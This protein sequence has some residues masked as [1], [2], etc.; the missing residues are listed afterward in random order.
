MKTYSSMSPTLLYS[1][2]QGDPCEHAR[3]DKLFIEINEMQ[4]TGSL[5]EMLKCNDRLP[6]INA[7][8]VKSLC[9]SDNDSRPKQSILTENYHNAVRITEK[10]YFRA[11]MLQGRIAVGALIFM[12]CIFSQPIAVYRRVTSVYSSRPS[13]GGGE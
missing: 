13:V 5:A 2:H 7:T 9:W 1:G 10:S 11:Y 4:L 3:K 12:S 6:Y 8:A